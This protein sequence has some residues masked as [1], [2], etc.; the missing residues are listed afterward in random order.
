MLRYVTTYTYSRS[1]IIRTLTIVDAAFPAPTIPN[2]S[3]CGAKVVIILQICKTI[4][5]LAIYDVRFTRKNKTRK[6]QTL[7]SLV[8]LRSV[9]IALACVSDTPISLV[10]SLLLFYIFAV[11]GIFLK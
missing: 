1:P 5:D 7:L 2:V 10:R 8:P 6:K 3:L 4:Y 11:L 9:R